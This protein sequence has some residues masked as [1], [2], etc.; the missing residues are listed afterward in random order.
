MA[1]NIDQLKLE[2][3][4]LHDTID[5]LKSEL[6]KTK[7]MKMAK[8][9][10]DDWCIIKMPPGEDIIGRSVAH[11]LEVNTQLCEAGIEQTTYLIISWMKHADGKHG[12]ILKEIRMR[13]IELEKI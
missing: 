4:C 3:C 13:E 7:G 11:I 5:K 9:K 2:N 8:F 6:K 10:V 12:F 1:D